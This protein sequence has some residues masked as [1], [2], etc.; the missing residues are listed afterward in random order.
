[1]I[2][3][4]WRLT[5]C[6][7]VFMRHNMSHDFSVQLL[8]RHFA[9]DPSEKLV[10][11][12][13]TQSPWPAATIDRVVGGHIVPKSW[14]IWNDEL[15]PYEFQFL[16][17]HE[18][19]CPKPVEFP[20]AFVADLQALLAKLELTNLLGV[21][22]IDHERLQS[23]VELME[24]TYGRNSC[25]VPIVKSEVPKKS[26]NAGWSF[27]EIEAE[28]R[29]SDSAFTLLENSSLSGGI[30]TL[31]GTCSAA[32]GVNALHGICSAAEGV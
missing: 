15:H 3:F 28:T 32:E 20:K 2:I 29:P 22:T 30:E 21:T 17:M 1:M 10:E 7:D 6:R 4:A 23:G 9:M 13:L 24:I 8:H 11:Y 19:S 25:M 12:G 14:R 31:H 16:S 5:C 18:V 26:Y 27:V